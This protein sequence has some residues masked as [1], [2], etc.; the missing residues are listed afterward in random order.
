MTANQTRFYDALVTAYR[1]LFANDP[2]YAFS[3]SKCSPDEMGHKMLAAF[4]KGAGNHE[5]KGVKMA[6][7]AC[8]ISHS[9]KSVSEFVGYVAQQRAAKALKNASKPRKVLTIGL[10]NIHAMM[11]GVSRV[12]RAHDLVTLTYSDNTRE[13]ATISSERW[14]EIHENSFAI[15]S[16]VQSQ[17]KPAN[18]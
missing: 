9:L 14:A 13:A 10:S 16:E 4:V 11:T 8:G 15:V 2:A 7:Q 5:G 18:V 1:E 6:C 17:R 12:D 3:A